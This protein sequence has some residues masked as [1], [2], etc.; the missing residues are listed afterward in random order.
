MAHYPTPHSTEWFE[1]LTAA[2]PQQAMQTATLV[3]AAGRQDICSI[4]GDDPASD[5][6]L[7]RPAPRKDA[8]A[9]IRLCNDCRQIRAM[10]GETY[11]SLSER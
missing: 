11:R 4:C 1:A 3:K 7:I 5:Y 9:S 10:H 6:K 2:N 8:V